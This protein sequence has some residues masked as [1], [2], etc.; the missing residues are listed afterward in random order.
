MLV[1][2]LCHFDIFTLRLQRSLVWHS[3][4]SCSDLYLKEK[5]RLT[6]NGRPT[7][8]HERVQKEAAVFR[9]NSCK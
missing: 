6:V 2:K 3:S 1:L 9:E 8:P 4:A 7:D 5:K